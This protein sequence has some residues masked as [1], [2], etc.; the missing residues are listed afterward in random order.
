LRQD[1]FA[2]WLVLAR[3]LVLVALVAVLAIPR[4]E[5]ARMT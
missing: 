4:R 3:D 2:S 1:A 5:P